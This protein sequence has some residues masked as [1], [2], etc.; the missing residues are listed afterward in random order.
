M[1]SMIIKLKQFVKKILCRHISDS[2][3]TITTKQ[4]LSVS[5]IEQ[6]NSFA[7]C[8]V[9]FW[10]TRDLLKS[11]QLK[12]LYLQH[13]TVW[14][15]SKYGVFSGPYFPAL[16]RSISSY[17]VRMWENTDQKKLRIWTLF[18]LYFTSNWI[19]SG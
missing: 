14:K 3:I 8:L 1:C 18:T 4:D 15:V 17:S 2:C 5:H 11:M 6:M 9:F 10:Q 19:S 13:I 16:G 7:V 12:W